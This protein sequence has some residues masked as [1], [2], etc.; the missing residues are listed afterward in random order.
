[1][2]NYSTICSVNDKYYYTLGEIMENIF[3]VYAYLREDLTPYYIGKGSKDRAWK[4]HTRTNGTNLLPKDP[5]RIVLLKESLSEFEAYDYESELIKQHGRKD[6]GTG[7]LHNLTD[8][9]RGNESG[10][11]HT[12]SAIEKLR[13]AGKTNAQKRIDSGT[14]NFVND[15]PKVNAG[16]KITKRLVAEGKHNLLKRPDGTSVASNR[17]ASG[18]HHFVDSEW[19]KQHGLNHSKW[20][21]EQIDKG[22]YYLINNNPAKIKVCCIVCQKETNPMGLSRF[23]N[24]QKEKNEQTAI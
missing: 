3:Y 20:I 4:S 14:H 12:E 17:V 10:Y 19:K 18:T 22:D 8:G 7:I 1:M 21:K 16:G 13:D 2:S 6:L 24:H 11:K 9:G 23:H 5:T 15:P